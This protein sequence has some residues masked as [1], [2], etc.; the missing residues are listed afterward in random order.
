MCSGFLCL[1]RTGKKSAEGDTRKLSTIARIAM[2]YTATT[3][4]MNIRRPEPETNEKLVKAGSFGVSSS[5]ERKCPLAIHFS[6][7][8]NRL[9]RVS[10]DP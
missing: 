5:S 2:A 7:K 1:L 10:S 4:Q 6:L 8:K 3:Q 9:D